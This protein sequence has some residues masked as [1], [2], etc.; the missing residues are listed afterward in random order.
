MSGSTLGTDRLAIRRFAWS[1]PVLMHDSECRAAT[2]TDAVIATI[3]A[4]C[5]L[6][7]PRSVPDRQAV[8]AGVTAGE[9]EARRRSG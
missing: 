7:T 2:A 3:Q 4:T 9:E 6:S 1:A 5:L 8:D